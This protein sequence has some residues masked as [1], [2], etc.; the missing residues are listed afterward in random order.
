M[1]RVQCQIVTLN[2]TT[3]PRGATSDAGS[4]PEEPRKVTT[5][6]ATAELLDVCTADWAEVHSGGRP[7]VKI[8]GSRIKDHGGKEKDIHEVVTQ[9]AR[10]QEN[11]ALSV[12]YFFI[13]CLKCSFYVGAG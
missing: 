3:G 9:L 6:Q 13:S 4:A 1:R 7:R 2:N 11:L 5:L 10:R 8:N 12:K